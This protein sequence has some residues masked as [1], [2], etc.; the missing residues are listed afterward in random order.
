MTWY[1]PKM[2]PF[3][4]GQDPSVTKKCPHCDTALEFVSN[5][6]RVVFTAHDDQF[7][8]W[9][10]RERVKLLEGVLLAQRESYERHVDRFKRRV[11]KM[12]A[13]HGIPSIEEQAKAASVEH[14]IRVKM[15]GLTPLNVPRDI[16]DG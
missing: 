8:M 1:R 16:I 4:F 2:N 7:C 13:E 6:Q 11:N 12:L 14:E 5:G 9:A 15:A 10:T 3:S